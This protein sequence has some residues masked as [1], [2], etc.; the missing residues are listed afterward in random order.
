MFVD[1]DHCHYKVSGISI[2]GLFSV[3]VSTPT[4][5]L[6]KH[7]TAVQTSIFG[8]NFTSLNKAFEESIIIWY[9]LRSIGVNLSKPTPVFLGNVSVVLNANDPGSTL[10]KKTMAL[11][12]Y[13]VREHIANNVVEVKKIHTSDN[14]ADIFAKPL[15][16][17]Y[18]HGFYHECIY[19]FTLR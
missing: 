17:N 1:Y 7:Q 19:N 12:Y 10:N 9:R 18:Y 13:F 16:I 2:T 4:T 5:S 6:S 11:R 8:A 3:V 15:V 14:F